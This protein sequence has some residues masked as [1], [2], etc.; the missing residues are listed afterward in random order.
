MSPSPR[1]IILLILSL[2]SPAYG[3]AA[4]PLLTGQRARMTPLRVKALTTSKKVL[5]AD[6]VAAS[7]D[8]LLR[9]AS[10]HFAS[11]ALSAAV[12]LKLPDLIGD[13][14]VTAA[15]LAESLRSSGHA[16]VNGDALERTMRLLCA[17][18]V[19]E[20]YAEAPDGRGALY[21]LTAVGA[22]LQTGDSDSGAGA[23]AAGADQPSLACAVLHWTDPAQLGAWS[24]LP[25]LILGGGGLVMGA[26]ESGLVGASAFELANGEGAATQLRC[27]PSY[28]E[29]VRFIGGTEVPAI[30]GAYDWAAVGLGGTGTVVD[31]GGGYGEL[32]EALHRVQPKLRC[33]NFD[34]AGVIAEAPARAGVSHVA[35]DMFD[36]STIPECDLILMKHV[37]ADWSDD[38]AARALRACAA[39]LTITPGGEQRGRIVVADVALPVGQEAN[40]SGHINLRVDA[41]L[42]LTGNRGERTTTRWQRVATAAGLVVEAFVETPSPSIGLVV[43]RSC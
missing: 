34:L 9:L 10:E 29:L 16:D 6:E 40:G 15:D 38:D 21:R 36:T 12:K 7:I 2:A 33:V 28:G 22:L 41:L 43:L 39:A 37:L 19:L 26:S 13:G 14:T 18:G 25:E 1:V 11:L 30:L 35:G 20:H 17:S 5:S 42:A 4:V 32:S 27:D 23:G 31:I 8:P 3:Y 24:K